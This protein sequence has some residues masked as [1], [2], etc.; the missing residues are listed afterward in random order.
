MWSDESTFCVNF[1]TQKKVMRLAYKKG[2]AFGD[3]FDPQY[4]ETTVTHPGVK[5]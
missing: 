1:E 5:I 4:L 2:S 3:P